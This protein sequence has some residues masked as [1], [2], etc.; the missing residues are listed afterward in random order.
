MTSPFQLIHFKQLIL[1][2]WEFHFKTKMRV[3]IS[4]EVVIDINIYPLLVGT[5]RGVVH[6]ENISL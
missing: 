2:L 6:A 5:M 3:H 1:T 4:T